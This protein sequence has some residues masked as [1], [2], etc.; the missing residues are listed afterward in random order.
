VNKM[1]H[2][3]LS[4][5][6]GAMFFWVGACTSNVHPE[7]QEVALITM[8]PSPTLVSTPF[9]TSIPE[10]QAS[11]TPTPVIQRFDVTEIVPSG[12]CGITPSKSIFTVSWIS[13]DEFLFAYYPII[14]STSQE[15]SKTEEL[16]WTSHNIKTGEEI[17]G[18]P[19]ISLNNTF[20]K[21]NHIAISAEQPEL[22]GYFSPSMK[23]VIYSVFIGK[24]FEPSAKNEIW[25]A[26]AN[27][28][29]KWKIYES[30]GNAVDIYRAAWFENET[31]VIFNIAYEGPTEFYVSDFK[32]RK[33]IKLSEISQFSGITEE[34]WR[35][36]PNGKTLAAVDWDRQ[37]LLVSLET[38][39]I[40]VVETIGG[41][42][43]QWSN[44]GKFLFYW[45]RTDKDDWW[46]IDELRVYEISSGKISTLLDK[47]DLLAGFREYQGDDN[48]I[49]RDYYLG[50][51]RYAISP[52][53][54]SILLWDNG[55]YLLVKK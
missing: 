20:W 25:V 40:Q 23:Y 5:I 48:C 37:L 22:A 21:R 51:G 13:E 27:G 42:F 30:G 28:K 54:E 53:Q 9:F 6:V 47:S 33:S 50:G 3:L 34:T 41:S 11:K 4:L 55:L 12:R 49:S 32:S 39:E 7:P 16:Q 43:P 31:K 1:R 24:S 15:F 45:W 14:E 2:F 17:P 8:T 46:E 44:D 26:E 10:K 36:S 19:N 38:G 35:L 18:T 29:Q 52:N